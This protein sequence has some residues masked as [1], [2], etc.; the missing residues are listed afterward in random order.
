MHA[1]LSQLG[2]PEHHFFIDGA[3]VAPLSGDAEAVRNPMDDSVIG[4]VAL[5]GAADADR[6]LEAAGRAQAAWARRP[7]A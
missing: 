3:W 5:G 7:A 2:I 1:F 4:S 6:A